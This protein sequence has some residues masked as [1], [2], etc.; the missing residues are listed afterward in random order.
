MKNQKWEVVMYGCDSDDLSYAIETAQG[1]YLGDLDATINK[2]KRKIEYVEIFKEVFNLSN[3]EFKDQV[4]RKEVFAV[5]DNLKRKGIYRL[6]LMSDVASHFIVCYPNELRDDVLFDRAEAFID[7]ILSQ[8]EWNTF[9]DYAFNLSELTFLHSKQKLSG[10]EL[11]DKFSILM[12]DMTSVGKRSEYQLKQCEKLKKCVDGITSYFWEYELA[13][14][15][16][17]SVQ[18]TDKQFLDLSQKRQEIDEILEC[19]VLED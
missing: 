17:P 4:K 19:P 13:R 1:G 16:Y 14:D 2:L 10:K 7:D 6:W 9:G 11:M 3:I 8:M 15:G 5:I 18:L 12:N